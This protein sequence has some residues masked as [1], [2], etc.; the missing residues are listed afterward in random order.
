MMNSIMRVLKERGAFSLLAGAFSFARRR[1]LWIGLLVSMGC[2]AAAIELTANVPSIFNPNE[3]QFQSETHFLVF[4]GSDVAGENATTAKAYY[5]AIDPN[6]AKPTFADWL[7]NAGFIK[8][9]SQWHPSGAQRIACDLPGCDLPKRK[10][11]GSLNYGDNIINTD[12]HA[13]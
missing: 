8:D 1:S 4:T 9:K 12:S 5:R 3:S 6:N 2:L 13:I 7:V 11:D 10:P